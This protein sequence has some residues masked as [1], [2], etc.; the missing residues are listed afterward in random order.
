[1]LRTLYRGLLFTGKLFA[2]LLYTEGT[3]PPSVIPVAHVCLTGTGRTVGLTGDGRTI[4]LT[5]TGGDCN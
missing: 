4:S 2:G 5:G 3:N 1:M